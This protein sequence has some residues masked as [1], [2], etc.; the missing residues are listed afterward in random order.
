MR[1]PTQPEIPAETA[2][3][4]RRRRKKSRA[5]TT[6]YWFDRIHSCVLCREISFT[7][8]E[9]AYVVWVAFLLL[10]FWRYAY[11]FVASPYVINRCVELAHEGNTSIACCALD[12]QCSKSVRHTFGIYVAVT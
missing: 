8:L 7:F 1:E 6:F 9:L 2:T 4:K 11:S 10:I 12:L 3:T 5:P